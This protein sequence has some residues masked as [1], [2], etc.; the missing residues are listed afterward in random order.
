MKSW[1]ILEND[2]GVRRAVNQGWAWPGLFL[3]WVWG[4]TRGLWSEAGAGLGATVFA[5][6]LAG[7]DITFGL[8]WFT[9][10]LG[11]GA[12]P[13]GT[14]ALPTLA[15][16]AVAICF[17]VHGNGARIRRL[18]QAG[19]QAQR[20]RV[21]A[22]RRRGARVRGR[23]PR[24]GGVTNGALTVVA[25]PA[26][27]GDAMG[28]GARFWDWIAARYARQPVADEAAWEHK[29]AVTRGY[30]APD[31]DVLEF[32][33][34]TGSTALRHAADVRRI[35][36]IDVSARMIAIARDKAVAAGV[37]NVAFARG[38]IE[39]HAGADGM[40][41][42]VLGLNVLHLAAD[43]ARTIARVAALLRPGG[44]FVTSTPCI[45]D[46]GPPMRAVALL[47]RG[48]PVLPAVRAF[49]E[50]E[51]VRMLETAGFAIEYRWQP[52]PGKAV[53]IVARRRLSAP[54]AAGVPRP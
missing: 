23:T 12:T 42:A 36:A 1:L 4:V 48:L 3:S 18:E 16:L 47:M 52:G 35:E 33:C 53:F 6:V 45:A 46:M 28:R 49:G 27:G 41:D 7:R 17:A 14:G 34:G 15:F 19:F 9:L 5:G 25:R 8:W 21:R 11:D 43:P 31:M 51:W 29:L 50:G 38:A 44:V 20:R 22:Q 39:E 37:D 40:M 2:V 24:R 13:E 54:R 32:G 26:A 10:R 30:P